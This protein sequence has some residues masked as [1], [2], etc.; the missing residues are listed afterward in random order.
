MKKLI[1]VSGM[2]A[3]SFLAV[4]Q[5]QDFLLGQKVTWNASGTYSLD[6][7]YLPLVPQI[8]I[9]EQN[10][11]NPANPGETLTAIV[12]MGLNNYTSINFTMFVPP[13]T[14]CNQGFQIDEDGRIHPLSIESTGP[15]AC[16]G[17]NG[18]ICYNDPNRPFTVDGI[19]SVNG[20]V[21]G[22]SSGAHTLI[23]DPW[24]S[25]IDGMLHC[26]ASTIIDLPEFSIEFAVIG[27]DLS[28]VITGGVGPFTTNIVPNSPADDIVENFTAQCYTLTVIDQNTGCTSTISAYIPTTCP[29]D[30]NG[31]GIVNTQDL[32]LF[33]GTY[34]STG[35]PGDYNCDS[36]VDT[37]DLLYF[38]G[39]FG[40]SC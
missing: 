7:E 3:L 9:G 4:A 39:G 18:Q 25:S 21:K 13:M 16:G 34:A 10:T 29:G 40:L 17:N 36:I 33:M 20:C 6:M 28:S 5:C 8:V 22:L 31:D 19:A 2:I 15:S 26:N 14:F 38:L 27:N 30:F 24:L 11:W 23:F 35:G 37:Q 1:L 32:L 12:S